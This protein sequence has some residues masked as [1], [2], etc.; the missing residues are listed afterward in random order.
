MLCPVC[1]KDSEKDNFVEISKF[2][3]C[4]N[5]LENPHVKEL[6]KMNV[7]RLTYYIFD[8]SSITKE[9]VITYKLIQICA[10]LEDNS[11][12]V[13]SSFRVKENDSLLKKV[14]KLFD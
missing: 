8:L 1:L 7:K 3:V 11:L 13:L 5:C 12:Y 10:K 6:K 4:K 2:K 14:Y 9:G